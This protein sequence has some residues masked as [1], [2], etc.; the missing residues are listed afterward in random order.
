MLL[1]MLAEPVVTITDYLLAAEC[2]VFAFLL[3]RGAAPAGSQRLRNPF[4][5]FFGAIA[6]ATTA[7][8]SV[9]GFFPEGAPTIA[10]ELLW[11]L[12]LLALGVAAF[13]LWWVSGDLLFSAGMAKHI[14]IAALI[15]LLAYMAVVLFGRQDFWIAIVNYVPAALAAL[16]AMLAVHLRKPQA[17]LLTGAGGLAL[18]LLASYLQQRGIGLHPVYFN[19]NALYHALQAVALLFIFVAARRLS[20]P[21]AA[22]KGQTA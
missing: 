12:T 5:L 1:S 11:T 6:T 2:G 8:G 18:A 20:T 19:H 7:G 15:E 9:H 3:A 17:G 22:A 14:R 10:G 21:Q 4:V 16:I 13:S